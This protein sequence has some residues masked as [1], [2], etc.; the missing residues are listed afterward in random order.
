MSEGYINSR[1]YV[2][3]KP[4]PGGLEVVLGRISEVNVTSPDPAL[5]VKAEQAL[6]GLIGEVLHLP[7][8]KKALV[9]LRK[10]GFGQISG[11]IKRLGSDPSRAAIQLT[12]DPSPPSPLQGDIALDNNGNVGSGEWRSSATL[13]KQNLMRRGDLALV[14]FE[15]DADGQLELGTGIASLTYR[16]PLNDTLSLTGS[17][18]YSYRRFVEFRKPAFDFNFRTTQGLLQFEQEITNS[19]AWRWTA[20]TGI[21]INRTSSFEGEDSIP[22]V[23]GG[24]P[25]GY[26]KSGN[27]KLSTNIGHQRARSSWNANLYFLQGLA[28][29]TKGSHRHNLKLQGTDIG[30]ARAIGGLLDVSWLISPDLVWRGRAAGQHAFAPLP[31]SMAFSLGSDVGLRGLPGSLVSGD[32]GWLASTELVWTAWKRDQQALQ[33]VPFIGIGGIH[34]DVLGVTLE[35]SIGSGGLLGRYTNGRWQFELGWVDTFNTDDNPGLW[36]DWTLGH[37]LHIKVRYSL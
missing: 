16:Y 12:V 8:L 23:L 33:L 32:S 31:S 13:L 2:L 22:L 20:A 34:T 7:T 35:D 21:S 37:G 19:D 30:E 18:G 36:N 3:Q 14:Y 15:L 10:S 17:I 9:S 25:D 6:S 5:K 28:G 11:G 24:G 4:Q 27:L 26:L 1:V 29:V